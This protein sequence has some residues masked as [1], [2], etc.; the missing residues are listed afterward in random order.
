[1]C[2]GGR[3]NEVLDGQKRRSFFAAV[4]AVDWTFLKAAPSPSK[5]RRNSC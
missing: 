5:R 1:M 4:N 3:T 2:G